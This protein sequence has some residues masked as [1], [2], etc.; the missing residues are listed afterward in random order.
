MIKGRRPR[1]SAKKKKKKKMSTRVEVDWR[2]RE[3]RKP[4]S[5][6]AKKMGRTTTGGIEIE[7]DF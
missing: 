1:G 4:R 3:L 7:I 2:G 6:R 5:A